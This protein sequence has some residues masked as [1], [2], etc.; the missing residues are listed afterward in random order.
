MR[1]KT[2]V[3]DIQQFSKN[4]QIGFVKK[5][6]VFDMLDSTNSTA[7]DFARADA[8]EGTII[9]ART[10]CKGRGRFDRM[11]QSPEGGVYLSIILRPQIPVQSVS[12]LSFV[13]ALSVAKTIEAHGVYATIK[14]PNDVRVKKKKIAGIL[15]ESEIKGDHVNYVIVGIGINLNIDIEELPSDIRS[16][17]TSLSFELGAPLEY[18]NFLQT[19]LVQFDNVYTRLNQH[20]DVRLIGEWKTLSDTLGKFVR[21][22]TPTEVLQGTAVDVNQSGFLLLKTNQGEIKK[23][24]SGDCLYFDELDHT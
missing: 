21:V 7:K 22:Q 8:E 14:W 2:F 10:Q 5:L 24:V 6:L 18:Q 1:K 20:Q 13:A 15:L 11:W 3:E 23:I 16:R 19:L 9:I 12:L 4:L 17:S